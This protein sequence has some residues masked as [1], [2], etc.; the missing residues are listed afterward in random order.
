EPIADTP[1]EAAAGADAVITMVVDAPQVEEV[2]F[3]ENGAAE[4]LA[5]GALAIDMST[6]AASAAEEIA[7][8]LGGRGIGFLDAPVTGSAPRA[9]DGTL[10]IMVG[11]SD[12]DFERGRPL[13][14][15]MGELIVHCGPT[16]HGAMVKLLNNSIAATNA[17]TIAEALTVGERYGLDLERLL[18]VMRA[19]SAGS[20]MADLK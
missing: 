14:E 8:R 4:G 3:G 1:R 15:A 9:E 10:T 2:L 11:G 13:L 6:I 7:A 5:E 20:V 19:S 17:A 12:A 16:G 18:Q